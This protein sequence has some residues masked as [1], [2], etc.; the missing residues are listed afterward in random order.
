LEPELPGAG[1]GAAAAP[2]DSTEPPVIGAGVTAGVGT[3]FAGVGLVVFAFAFEFAEGLAGA[4]PVPLPV[5]EELSAEPESAKAIV[6]AKAV[7]LFRKFISLPD[8]KC[9]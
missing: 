5:A 6:S 3:G 9:Y 1:V 7:A 4:L 8:S 2:D